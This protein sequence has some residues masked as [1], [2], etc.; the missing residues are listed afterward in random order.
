[1]QQHTLRTH[2]RQSLQFN[3]GIRLI[4]LTTLILSGF[5]VYQYVS[6]KS[7]KLAHLTY[8]ADNTLKRLANNLVTPLWDIDPVQM[9][10]VVL[11]EMGE[12]IIS[13]IVVK[14]LKQRLLTARIRDEAWQIVET[15]DEIPASEVMR[16]QDILQQDEQL[17]TV[18]IHLT[19]QFMHTELAR[20]A[21]TTAIS[22][23]IVDVTIFFVFWF[24]LRTVL[25]RPMTRVLRF[26]NAIAAGDFTQ[27]IDIHRQDEIGKLTEAFRTMRTTIARMIAELQIK[28]AEL[29]R[30]DRLKDEFL[31]NTSHELRTPLNGIIGIADS[32]L[33]GA[34][35][36]LTEAQNYN[37]SLVVSS[38]RRLMTLVNDILDFS[39][40]KHHELQ[41]QRKPL[42]LRSL[43]D[44]VLML[45]QPLVSQKPV[46]LLNRI[47]AEAPAADADE[48]RV[49]QILHNLVGNGIKFTNEGTVTVSAQLQDD[50]VA[51]TVSD[52]GIGIPAAT[53]PQIFEAFEQADGSTARKYGGTGL[54][55]T[56]TKQLVELHG[57][58][59]GVTSEVDNG[60]DFTF[61]LPVADEAAVPVEA[62]DVPRKHTQVASLAGLEAPRP[63]A[64]QISEDMRGGKESVETQAH[65]LVVDDDPVNLQVLKNHLGLQHYALTLA[66]NGSDALAAI[67]TGLP[68]DLVLLDVMM[69]GM[70]GYE[71]CRRLREQYPANEVP[72][73]LLTAK[74][75]VQ[76]L[77]AGF[78]AGANDYLTKPFSKEE[79]LARVNTHLRMKTLV[80]ENVRMGTEMELAQRIQTALLP[81]L[82][83]DVHPDFDITAIMLPAEEV[84]G[85]YYEILLDH[86]GALWFGIGDVTGHGMTSGLIM[87]MAQT[88]YST[89]TTALDFPVTPRDLVV[90]LNKVL[91]TNV[92]GRL[93]ESHFMTFTA[94]KYIGAGRFQ[95]AG[96]HIDLIIY[97]HKSNTC[98]RVETKGIWLNVLP[99]IVYATENA[100]FTLTIGDVLVLYTDGLTE[101]WNSEKEMLDIHRFID[102][103]HAHAH[104]EVDTFRDGILHDVMAWCHHIR[105]D[106]MSLVVA[107]RI[108]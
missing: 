93:H 13:A 33:D 23:L 62:A 102:I 104:E 105:N 85:D 5:G 99:D 45:L 63:L 103:I 39:T 89:L 10:E 96:A 44:V 38:G 77:V 50:M 57:G 82:V 54:G 43:T 9:H 52:T 98:E 16:R 64:A 81:V 67:D 47:T 97:R 65:L 2:W 69:P 7:E 30:M 70:S 25:L 42:D 37:V 3:I 21:L 55:L 106:D 1:M 28:N 94:L 15:Q 20:G 12:R 92:Q 84:G 46:R 71:V 107:R 86:E 95:H 29:E 79:L 11:S 26:A 61:T 87:M 36:P 19:Q 73:M 18:E 60:S 101:V 88:V 74:N 51:V 91:F 83:K 4:V 14:D 27:V 58:Q 34:V 59:I 32:M 48:N 31:A 56:V 80:A 68:P 8:R 78:E 41:L 22:I 49:Q 24:S 100:E 53:Q 72:V 108:K 6:L 40:L 90:M 75:Q 35:G 17:G 76:D 66:T